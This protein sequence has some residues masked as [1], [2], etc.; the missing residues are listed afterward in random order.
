MFI[1]HYDKKSGRCITN[2]PMSGIGH[3]SATNIKIVRL[4][5][6]LCTTVKLLV[7]NQSLVSL[8]LPCNEN[9]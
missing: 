9:N 6:A 4:V 5:M 7:T 2:L 1:R 3:K 8:Y